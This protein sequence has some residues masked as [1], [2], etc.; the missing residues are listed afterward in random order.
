MGVAKQGVGRIQDAVGGLRGDGAAQAKSKLAEAVGGR[1][2][3]VRPVG[4]R[5]RDVLGGGLEAVRSE[6][7]DHLDAVE[8]YVKGEPLP[9]VAIAASVGI[10]LG[11]LSRA[12][13][14]GTVYVRDPR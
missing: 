14:A 5:V 8:T 2:S 10:V 12:D 7:H 6:I 9:A 13:A 1:P 3:S 11:L 4:R